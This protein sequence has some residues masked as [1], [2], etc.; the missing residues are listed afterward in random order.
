MNEMLIIVH[1]FCRKG[2]AR[3]QTS[4]LFSKKWG[5]IE[6]FNSEF[7]LKVQFDKVKVFELSNISAPYVIAV[8]F[9]GIQ[10]KIH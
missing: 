1:S 2:H 7:R 6:I 3:W 5:L 4:I 10:R 8:H 9:P